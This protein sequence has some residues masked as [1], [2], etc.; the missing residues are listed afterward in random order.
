MVADVIGKQNDKSGPALATGALLSK[1]VTQTSS[2]VGAAQT[3][4]LMVHLKQLTPTPKLVTSVIG[5]VGFV[6]VPL[7][8]TSVH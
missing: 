2:K 7:P 3:P 8:D 5:D 1:T 6:K 4:V